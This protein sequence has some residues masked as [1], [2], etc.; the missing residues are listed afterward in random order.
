MG[1][2]SKIQEPLFVYIQD[3]TEMKIHHHPPKIAKLPKTFWACR[4]KMH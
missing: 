4:W 1:S 2:I 3:K